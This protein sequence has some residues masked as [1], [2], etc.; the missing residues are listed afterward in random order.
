[1]NMFWLLG[2]I[3]CYGLFIG[4]GSGVRVSTSPNVV[5]IGAILSFNSSIGKVAKVAIEAAVEDVNSNPAVLK[6]TKLKLATQDTKQ[7]SGFLGIIEGTSSL[8]HLLFVPS[9]FSHCFQNGYILYYTFHCS[10]TALRFM[11]NDT[12]AIVGPQQSVMAHI[13]SHIANELQVPLLSFAATDPTLNS[14]QFPYFVRTTQSDTFQ[15]AAVAEILNYYKWR[16]V[17]A[18]Y[19][20][21]DHG[22]NGVAALG[23]KLAEKRCKISYRAP[24]SPKVGRNEISNTL[25]KVALMESRVIILHIYATWGLD[26]VDVARNMGMMESEYVWIATDWLSTVL[27]TESSLPPTAM[28]SIQGVLTLRMHTPDSEL[29]RKF[30]SRWSN[31]TGGVFGL[32]TYGLYAYDTI[33]LLAHA[34]DAFLNQGG[35]IS[36]SNDPRLTEFHGGNLHFDSMSI[37]DEGNMLLTSILE[38]NISGVSG[39]IKFTSEGN[40]IGTAYEVINVIGTT[41]MRRIG[42]WSNSSGLST[43]P[44]EE[45]NAKINRSRSNHLYGV[46]W[47]G[48]TTVK[49]RGWVFSSNGKQLRVGVPVRISFREFATRVEGSDVFHGY[50]IDVFNAALALLPYAVPYKFI[51][52]GDGHRVPIYDNLLEM[53]ATNV[54]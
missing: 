5:N 41:G 40:L 2:V 23:D 14:L 42:Y 25:L 12:V 45:L 32:N 27:D 24:L 33:W 17:I 9:Q 16:D 3:F 35:N 10:F 19:I 20:D 1:M 47:P 11:E 22:R 21:D 53:I 39:P 26:V 54:S 49:P 36:F 34:L 38:V 31:L 52:F 7:S 30:V 50:C 4:T 43:V 18:I 6:E 46:I 15:M 44:P 48:Q 8:K 51:P 29:K 13:I 28:D 37:F